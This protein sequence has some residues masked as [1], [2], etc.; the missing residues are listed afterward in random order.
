MTTPFERKNAVMDTE[1]FLAD[2]LN[3]KKTPRIPKYIRERA[4]ALLK[5]Y[6]HSFEMHMV[7]EREDKIDSKFKVFGE[8]LK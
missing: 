7:S 6:P 3:P 4:S 2:L 5:H 1:K 8:G